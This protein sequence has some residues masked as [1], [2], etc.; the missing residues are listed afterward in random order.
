MNFNVGDLVR[1]RGQE[2]QGEVVRVNSTSGW[3]TVEWKTGPHVG[4]RP[5]ICHPKE[6][7]AWV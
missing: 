4:K 2:W 1:K 6:L 3:V 7:E 5:M